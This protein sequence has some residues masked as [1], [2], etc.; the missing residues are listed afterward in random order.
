MTQKRKVR[1]QPG[2]QELFLATPADI[3]FYGGAAGGGKS[4]AL[5]MEALR[6]KKLKDYGAVIFRRTSTDIR[7][8]GAIW[9][10]SFDIF[11]GAAGSPNATELKWH[12]GSGATIG[13]G[14]MEHEK[15]RFKWQGSQIAMI[16]FDELTHFTE[17]QFWYMLSRNRSV[18]PIRPYIRATCNPEPDSWVK[19]LIRWWLDDEGE[20]ADES[21]AGVIRWFVRINDEIMWEDSKE[22]I[23]EKYGDGEDIKPL[24]FTFIPSKLSD[25]PLMMRKDPDYESKLNAMPLVDREQL[26]RGNWKIRR[27]AGNIFKREWF[28]IV[29][30]M[31]AGCRLVRYWDFAASEPTPSNPD[32]DWT[33]GGLI[34]EGPDK[35]I[36]IGEP[37]HFQATWGK[38]KTRVKN[39]AKQ[40]GRRVKIYV[41]QEPGSSGKVTAADL[42]SHLSGF[43]ARVDKVSKDKVDRAMPYSAQCEAGNVSLIEGE[44]NKGFIDQHVNFSGGD[45][46]N[47]LVDC[48]SGGFNMLVGAKSIDYSKFSKM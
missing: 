37:A 31:P 27:E 46:K 11:G 9:D 26:K 12:F 17:L 4:Y 40:D 33:A 20:Y 29:P 22:A 10:E 24:S 19:I 15:D 2:K 38:V 23:H 34:G 41:E 28:D 25:N 45:E 43:N 35:R 42:V 13:F 5:M 48:T 7:K 8:Q 39:V 21:K 3:A 6:H 32:P 47:D 16:G 1:P 18:C 36:Y 30:A 14:H 44:W